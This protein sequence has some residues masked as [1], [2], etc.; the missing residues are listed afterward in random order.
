MSKILFEINYNIY[1]KKREKYL[2]CVEELK[3]IIN[4]DGEEKYFVYEDSK[5]TNNFSEIY[6]VASEEELEEIED[7]QE[8]RAR[9]LTAQ[10][11]N[12]FILDKKVIYTTKKEI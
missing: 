9:E 5:K 6:I 11:F 12:D 2:D 7:N 4:N 8:E 3:L 1:P 10:L